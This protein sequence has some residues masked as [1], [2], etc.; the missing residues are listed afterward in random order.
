MHKTLLA[1]ALSALVGIGA[2]PILG[3]SPDDSAGREHFFPL[4]AD[5]GGFQSWLFVTNVS[6]AANQCSLALRGPDLDPGIFRANDAVAPSGANATIDLAEAGEIITLASTGARALT[7]GYATLDCAEPVTARM[8]L[9]LTSGSAPVSMTTLESASPGNAFQ[10]P[11]LPRLGQLA[12]VFSSDTGLDAI[13]A[14]ELEDE[15]GASIGG[16]NVTVPAK[17]TALQML[18]ELIPIPDD[19]SAGAAR[20]S[21]NRDVAILG[22]P[23]NGHI[24]TAMPA[25][26]LEDEGAKSSHILPLILDGGGFRSQLILTN[27]AETA[28]QCTIGLRGAGLNASRF[29]A[30]AGAAATISGIAL[31]LGAKGDQASLPSAGV[32]SATFGYATV[33][34]DRPLAAR[35][36]LTA[37]AAGHP[38]GMAA[39]SGA[40][41]ANGFLFPVVPELGRLALILNNIA[42]T[43]ASCTAELSQSGNTASRTGSIAIPGR[44]STMHF[45]RDLFTVPAGFPGGTARLSCDGDVTAISLPVSG[46]VFAAMPPAVLSTVKS[47]DTTPMVEEGGAPENQT[48]NEGTPIAPLQLPE[49]T[50]GNG[51]LVYTLAPEV[52]GLVFDPATRQLTGTPTTAGEYAMTYMATDEDGDMVSLSFIIGVVVP[53]TTPGFASAG[54]PENRNYPQGAE[55][56]P[57]QLPE[58]TGGNGE[59]VYTLA[60]EVPGLV[61]DPATRQLTGTPTTPGEYEMVYTATDSDGDRS[62]LFFTITID[63]DRTIGA[64]VLSFPDGNLR[65][66]LIEILGKDSEEPIY[67]FE[68]AE[69]ESLDARNAGIE[70]LEGLQH[71][72]GLTRLN[73]GPERDPEVGSANS[74][75]VTDLSAVF[76]LSN[77]EFLDLSSA[78][79]SGPIPSEIGQLSSLSYLDLSFNQMSGS[80]PPELGKLGNLR[81]LHLEGNH[82]SG[83]IPAELGQLSNLEYLGLSDNLLTG[84]I[85][86]EFGQ[87][88]N[89]EDLYLAN[90]SLTNS[91]PP[92]LGKLGN[93]KNLNLGTNQ[94]SG[95]IP[96]ELGQLSNLEHL[97]LYGNQFTGAMPSEFG[98]LGSLRTLYLT[99]NRQLNGP[100]PSELGQL[101]N[102]EFLNLST[103]QLMGAIPPELGQLQN[104][105]FLNITHNEL[106]GPIPPEIGQLSDLS[107]LALSY[108][109]LS[110]PIPSEIGQLSSLSYLDLSFNQMS[111]SIP[112]QLAN[113][114]GLT[115]LYLNDNA[116]SGEV[117]PALLELC[118]DGSA[119][120]K[121]DPGLIHYSIDSDGDGVAD[122]DD[123]F[124]HDAAKTADSDGDGIDDGNDPSPQDS[125]IGDLRIFRDNVITMP[126][127]R[128]LPEIEGSDF[129]TFTQSL[130][131]HFEDAFDIVML[132]TNLGFGE[133]KNSW[134]YTGAAYSVSND[135]RGI[136]LSDFYQASYGSTGKLKQFIHM[137]FSRGPML[138]EVMHTWANFAI[139]SAYGG[140]WGFSSAYGI[141]GGFD[142]A[143]LQDLGNGRYSAA[144]FGTGADSPYRN[145]RVYSELE[146]YLAGFIPASEVPDIL[147][148]EDGE[149]LQ[150]GAVA[151]FTGTQLTMTMEDL[152]ARHGERV[153]SWEE[154][155]K[156]FRAAAVLIYNEAE[157]P[158]YDRLA[159]LSADIVE[160]SGTEP[161][162]EHESNFHRATRGLGTIKMDGL[163][164]L[165]RQSAPA[166]RPAAPLPPSYGAP[167]PPSHGRGHEHGHDHN[168]R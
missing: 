62:S 31:E 2:P 27:L 38:A 22:L 99:G 65:N 24:F 117:P 107:R 126:V 67:D 83:S 108:N 162:P 20:L 138:H 104:L 80:I 136:G 128:N 50:G 19:L 150:R 101:S 165:I 132:F 143:T 16:G 94:F 118:N 141:L 51:E 119:R 145:P 25:I 95:S 77:L 84:P 82:L 154:S 30:P 127:S 98:Q 92:E 106:D 114:V 152:I 3:Q 56:D 87:L 151:V 7:F 55:I 9:A 134:G 116:L 18:G 61:F 160:F 163:A 32:D 49:A 23:L 53:D 113:L 168:H 54:A 102:L 159:T 35:N 142:A 26:D 58:A 133:V 158:S 125:A 39:A 40:Q 91:I 64:T 164:D 68:L 73:L 167:P 148:F 43:E 57:L 139:P 70:S 34:C 48:F 8:L 115:N 89:L 137:P 155:Q 46:A 29:D 5:G 149:W 111:G 131:E 15:A 59:L 130:Y 52:P 86:S 153:P 63:P 21:C 1:G 4:I 135:I 60:P 33:D 124:P 13:C 93:L 123:A 14:V 74:N 122:F 157:P 103:N 37:D 105:E 11:V 79:Q 36:V 100:I 6:D 85:P 146:L 44:S 69:L 144:H 76:V 71:A 109:Q 112:P 10:F 129:P 75:R 96:A 161:E 97:Y 66:R 90:N 88:S 110:G 42:E 78:L 156:D 121:F 147:Y 47:S 120:C 17:S 28:N 166:S 140:H 41:P 81:N 45:L 12:M 72:A